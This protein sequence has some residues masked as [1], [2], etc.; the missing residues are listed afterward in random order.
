MGFR[1][2]PPPLAKQFPSRLLMANCKNFEAEASQAMMCWVCGRNKAD[3]R[4]NFGLEATIDGWWE[5]VLPIEAIYID[6]S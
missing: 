4:A 6:T 5:V 2:I 3:C 1:A